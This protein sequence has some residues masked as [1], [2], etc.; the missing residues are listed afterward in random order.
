MTVGAATFIIINMCIEEPVSYSHNHTKPF[1]EKVETLQRQKQ[2]EI[3]FYRISAD[4]DAIKFMVNLDKPVKPQFIN[5]PE[6]ILN[7]KEPAYFISTDKDFAD[8][9]KDVA[10]HL[11]RLAGGKIRGE[12]CVVFT[13]I[14]MFGKHLE[15]KQAIVGG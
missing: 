4:G 14:E 2:A 3:V 15:S 12:D 5:S 6:A 9:P 1:V 10:Q 11:K 7:C 8:L 13:R